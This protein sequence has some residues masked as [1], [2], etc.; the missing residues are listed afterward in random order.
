MSAPSKQD[1]GPVN[2][3]LLHVA[4]YAGHR[5]DEEPRRLYIG[6]REVAVTEIIDRWLD[7]D[8]RYFKLRGE[9]G[10]IYLVRHDIIADRWALTQHQRG[11]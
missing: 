4:C 3:D 11:P 1:T 6:G 10:G 7:P 5:A 9:D 8:H 2:D